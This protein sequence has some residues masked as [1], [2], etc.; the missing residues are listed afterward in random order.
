MLD[1]NKII[2]ALD[3]DNLSN[4][5]N[6]IN[7]INYD[8][9]YKVGMEFFYS[10]GLEGINKI[11]KKK[12]GIKIFLDLKLH[13][14][15][16]TV[17]SSLVPLIESIRPHMIT[18]HVS[19]GSV[20]LKEAVKAINHTCKKRNFVK[21]IILGVTILTSLTQENLKMLGHFN[22]IQDYVIKYSELAYKTGLNGIVCS[23][24]EIELVKSLYKDLII[25]T[26]GI[27]INKNNHDD[28]SRVVTPKKA[29][30]IGADFIVMGRPLIQSKDPNTVI[31]DIIHNNEQRKN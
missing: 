11:R 8:I 27:R 7:I 5:V 9:I 24:L 26:P 16:N 13:D 10:F 19:G 2:C 15:P 28:Q 14:I 23:A 20:M 3:F 29:F 21:P 6:F 25:V 22:P 18:L 12:P 31:S 30:S 17:S 4:A 1:S